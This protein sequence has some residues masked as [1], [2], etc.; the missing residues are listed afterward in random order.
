MTLGGSFGEGLGDVA[1][2][3]GGGE[4]EFGG[5]G[6]GEVGDGGGDDVAS[7]GVFDSHGDAEGG[8]EVAGLGGFGEAAEFA[9]FNVDN[10]H[11]EVG[12]AFEEHLEGVDVFIEDEGVCR[13]GGG[14][15]GILRR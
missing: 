7:P 12:M 6:M 2:E 8:A 9:D 10:V 3:V 1:V 11:G 5:G 13:Y 4:E 15:R 14:W